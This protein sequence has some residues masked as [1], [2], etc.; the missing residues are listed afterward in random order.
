MLS[1]WAHRDVKFVTVIS[2]NSSAAAGLLKFI[3]FIKSNFGGE[4]VVFRVSF[5]LASLNRD[6]AEHVV[7]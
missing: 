2:L 5:Y 1:Q 7:F 4:L 6:E 3:C